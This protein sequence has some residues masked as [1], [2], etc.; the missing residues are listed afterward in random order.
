MQFYSPEYYKAFQEKLDK[1]IS[2]I[3]GLLTGLVGLGALVAN[4][5]NYNQNDV[6]EIEKLYTQLCNE[7]KDE[8]KSYDMDNI[9]AYA[10]TEQI[11]SSIQELLTTANFQNPESVEALKV[12]LVQYVVKSAVEDTNISY[13][14]I[15]SLLADSNLHPV[16]IILNFAYT[17]GSV[18][19][20]FL[21]PAIF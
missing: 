13:L 16:G 12:Q 2:S 21:L 10:K 19:C 18:A 14:K 6:A 11:T 8:V 15:K 4:N 3:S 20:I 7:I 9:I 1:Q 5:G 17:V